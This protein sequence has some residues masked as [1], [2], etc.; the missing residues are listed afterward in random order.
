MALL[1]CEGFDGKTTDLASTV[2]SGIYQRGTTGYIAGRFGTGFAYQGAN[3]LS[4]GYS[5]W[6]TTLPSAK[7]TII[8]GV[9]INNTTGSYNGNEAGLFDFTS[10]GTSVLNLRVNPVGPASGVAGTTRVV[11]GAMNVAGTQLGVTSTVLPSSTWAHIEIKVMCGTGTSGSIT[12]RQNGTQTL[13]LTGIDTGSASIDG[14][15]LRLGVAGATAPNGSWAA[16]VDDWWVC[17]GTGSINNDFLGD[18]RVLA[19][20][21]IGA[22]SSTQLVPSTGSNWACV[23]EIPPVTTDYVGSSVI[24]AKDL[25]DFTVLGGSYTDIKG[26]RLI[27]YAQSS[28]AG[29]IKGRNICKSGAV[30]AN[31]SDLT[32]A[33]TVQVFS[34]MFETDPNTSAAWTNANINAAEFGWEVRS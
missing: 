14:V 17:D 29:V 19:M 20:V 9:A 26:A 27:S 12:V 23:D 8:T 28:D 34:S 1:H 32:M 33:P 21:P 2:Y 25:Y 6:H 13:A 10:G 7:T 22:G 18:C 16:I 4:T 11:R 30:T 24:G 31:G 3:G 15:G 5:Q